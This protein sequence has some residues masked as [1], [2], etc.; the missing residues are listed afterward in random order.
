VE[1]LRRDF[2]DDEIGK[3][4]NMCALRRDL[5]SWSLWG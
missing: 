1:G 5:E 3:I 4:P 2:E